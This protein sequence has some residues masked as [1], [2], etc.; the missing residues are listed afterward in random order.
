[1]EGPQKAMDWHCE[2]TMKPYK[3]EP[4]KGGSFAVTE[5]CVFTYLSV[6]WGE[7][8]PQFMNGSQSPSQAPLL[9]CGSWGLNLGSQAWQ[10]QAPL[11][12][13]SPHRPCLEF[14]VLLCQFSCRP[15]SIL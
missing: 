7:H 15:K 12:P 6:C 5:V 2:E 9:L 1:M 11:P 13:V 8:K 4:Y 14:S 10:Q 3:A